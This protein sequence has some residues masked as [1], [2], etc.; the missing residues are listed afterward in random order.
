M[1]SYNTQTHYLS[2]SEYCPAL[3][4]S[5]EHQAKFRFSLNQTA[6]FRIDWSQSWSAWA[7]AQGFLGDPQGLKCNNKPGPTLREQEGNCSTDL[8]GRCYMT[9]KYKTD[10]PSKLLL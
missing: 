6:Q 2:E 8:Y 5:S 10:I 1:L 3:R 7:S 4:Y 9:H